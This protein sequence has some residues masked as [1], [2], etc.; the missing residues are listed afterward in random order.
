MTWDWGAFII[1]VAIYVAIGLLDRRRTK[2]GVRRYIKVV[3]EQRA[4][5]SAGGERT[6]TCPEERTGPPV[7]RPPSA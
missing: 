3:E 6:G 7:T 1:I 2:I 5:S 4:R